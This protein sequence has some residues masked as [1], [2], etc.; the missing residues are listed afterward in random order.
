MQDFVLNI[1]WSN[2]SVAGP[3]TMYIIQGSFTGF[4]RSIV[5][6]EWFN[7]EEPQQFKEDYVGRI[8]IS[9]GKI[10]TDVN[11]GT[12]DWRL[13]YDKEGILIEDAHPI[14]E[15]CRKKKDKR[16]FGVIGDPRRKSSRAER[17]KN[18]GFGEGG[19]WVIDSN[20]NIENGDY[21]TSRDYLGYGEKQDDYILHNYT[22]AKILM[23]ILVRKKY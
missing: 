6:D 3:Y 14:I 9:T 16:I 1:I 12:D 4:H 19:L 11:M 22:C 18:N 21:I 5:N 2:D 8:V 13:H 20:G 10:A 7:N 17:L 15:L 23:I